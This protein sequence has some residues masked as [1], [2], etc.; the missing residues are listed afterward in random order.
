MRLC[1][2]GSGVE[3]EDTHLDGIEIQAIAVA[4]R[5]YFDTMVFGGTKIGLMGAFA[6]SFAAA[7][8]SIESVVPRWLETHDIIYEGVEPLFCANLSERKHLMF[9]EIDAVLVYPGGIGT[10]DE[11]F[12]LLARRAMEPDALCPP[13]YIYNWEHYYAPI[14]LQIETGLE[15]GLI[16]PHTVDTVFPFASVEGLFAILEQAHADVG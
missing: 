3:R 4:F 11:L 12:D 6:A 9:D 5:R 15:A 16:H 8:G 2:I 7:G 1:F 10:W 13:L 14:L